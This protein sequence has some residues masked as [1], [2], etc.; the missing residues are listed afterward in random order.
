MP[1]RLIDIPE[2][3]LDRTK[4]V[5]LQEFAPRGNKLTA[6]SYLNAPKPTPEV[7]AFWGRDSDDLDD[8]LPIFRLGRELLVECRCLFRNADLGV[9]GKREEDD[10]EELIDDE[11]WNDLYPMFVTD[12]AVGPSWCYSNIRVFDPKKYREPPEKILLDCIE[13]LKGKRELGQSLK[14]QLVYGAKRQFGGELTDLL[15]D[16]AYQA[17]FNK[18]RGRPHLTN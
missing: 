8:C 1:F 7:R 14:K 9:I 15:F 17:V 12:K 2:F 5:R 10:V 18:V 4:W 16:A 11:K 13:W 6:A 3:Y